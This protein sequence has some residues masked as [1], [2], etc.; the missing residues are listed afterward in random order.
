ML[1]NLEPY[2]RDMDFSTRND[3]ST[4]H[5]DLEFPVL[6]QR[7]FE[8]LVAKVNEIIDHLNNPYREEDI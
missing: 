8:A 4:N 1:D 3:F 7:S 5:E 2:T 6:S